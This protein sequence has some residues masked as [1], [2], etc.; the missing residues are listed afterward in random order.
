MPEYVDGK[1]RKLD[2]DS[3]VGRV[4]SQKRRTFLDSFL[5]EFKKKLNRSVGKIYDVEV[6][7]SVA[8]S[9]AD[10]GSD[11]DLLVKPKGTASK[12][13]KGQ[14]VVKSLQALDG[15]RSLPYKIELWFEEEDEADHGMTEKPRTHLRW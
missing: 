4:E 14:L 13:Q 10:S 15:F 12:I 9:M 6:V 2:R 1:G 3:T 11:I 8:A 7:G 5:P